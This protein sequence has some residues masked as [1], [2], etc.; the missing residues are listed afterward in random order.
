MASG[1]TMKNL[2]LKMVQCQYA[3]KILRR[4]KC[5]DGNV[6]RQYMIN[7]G[8]SNLMKGGKLSLVTSYDEQIEAMERLFRKLFKIEMEGFLDRY[9]FSSVSPVW[10]AA[11]KFL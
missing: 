4:G 8:K 7:S 11:L 1:A 2:M 9:V 6:K 5:S 3:Q 10:Y